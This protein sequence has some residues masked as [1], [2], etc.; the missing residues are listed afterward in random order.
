MET[1]R[2]RVLVVEDNDSMRKMLTSALGDE[3]YEVTA[4][5]SA[6]EAMEA[7]AER[8]FDAVIA[9]LRLPGKDGIAV[10]EECRQIDPTTPVI[11][12][13]AY[14]TIES[15]VRAVKLGAHDFI[16]K[17]FDLDYLLLMVSRL[18]RSQRLVREN[19]ALRAELG[20]R[21]GAPQII[22]RSPAFLKTIDEVRQVSDSDATVLLLGES[23]T[24]KELLARAIHALSPRQGRPFVA[25]NCAAIPETLIENELFGHERGAYT[26][27]ERRR[28]GK[29]ELANR[30]TLFLDEIADLPPALQAKLLRVLQERRFERVGGTRT[31][32][33]DVRIIAATNQDLRRLVQQ[34]RF[35]EDL[36]YRVNVF[37]ITIPPLRERP[38]DIPLLAEHFADRFSREMRKGRTVFSPEAMRRLQEYAWPGNVRELQNCIERAV[39]LAGGGE[40]R[41]EHL[42]FS[43]LGVPEVDLARIPLEGTLAEAAQRAKQ[44]VER[45]MIEAAMQRCGGNKAEMARMLGVNYKTLLQKIKEYG[46]KTE[47]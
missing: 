1:I 21:A 20:E 26:G 19:E 29:F 14:G 9:D 16:T 7:L 34:R 12:M 25:I 35:R 37:P 33:V 6:E 41:P 17:P 2:E 47:D 22:G 8:R 5:G 46:L 39:I 31:I 45:K 32:H 42:G 23:G 24:G 15:A 40:I 18:M 10:L 38:E 28:P 13:T 43:D 11:I 36:Y 27:A 3:G 44:Y 30:G 4:V